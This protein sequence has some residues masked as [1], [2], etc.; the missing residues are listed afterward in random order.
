MR[1]TTKTILRTGFSC[2]LLFLVSACSTK[3]TNADY[4]V[5]P[6]PQ[7][8]QKQEGEGFVLS[9][10]TT[11][12]HPEGNE[13]LKRIACFLSEYIQ[14]TTGHTLSVSEEAKDDNCIV[15][16]TGLQHDNAEAYT[17]T[18][19]HSQIILKGASPA[20]VFY[21]AQTLRKAIDADSDKADVLFAPVNIEDYP[22]FGYRGMM[23][24]ISRHFF[25]KEF[26]KT[27]I[28]LLALHN[29]NRFH[30]HLSDDQG[31]RIEIKKYPELTEK[32][33]MRK[34]TVIGNNT[35]KYD[36]KPYGGFYTQ[37]DAR[38][39]VAYAAERFITII[40]EIDLPGHMLAALKAYPQI[41]CTGGPYETA[42][43]WGV[44]DDV[45]CA[46]NEETYVFLKGVFDEILDIFPSEYIH[47]GGDECPKVRWKECPK[48]QAKIKE[49]KLKA[50]SHH[51]A[52]DRLQSYVI[53][54]MEEYLNSKG[55]KIIG[56]DE[57][58]EGGLAP[59]ATVMSWRGMNGAI[60]A[61]KQG[62]D[63]ILTPTS[64]FYFDYYQTLDVANAPIAFNGYVPIEKVYSFNP[65]PDVLSAD[66]A[67]HIIGVQA[68]LWTEY[69][70]SPEQALYMVLPRMDAL[71]E[72][73]WMMQENRDYTAFQQRL[74]RML[75]YYDRRGYNYSR[76]MFDLKV[77]VQ[78][79]PESSSVDV[80]LSTPDSAAIYYTLDGSTPT[81]KS[82]RYTEPVSITG[83]TDFQAAA[84]RS[85]VSSTVYEQHFEFNKATTKPVVLNQ[86]LH[87]SYG[88]GG[89]LS[90][91]NGIKGSP[92][93]YKDDAWLG[94]IRGD[95]E[96]K[97]DLEELTDISS[98]SFD[99]YVQTG[100]WVFGATKLMVSVS[101][102][103]ENYQAVFE[104]S[105]PETTEHISGVFP[106]KADFA[107]VKTRYVKLS[108]NKVNAMPE[109]HLG[110]GSPAF[111]F[112]DEIVIN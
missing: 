80:T 41:G 105:Y 99:T 112:M 71:A 1:K 83:S 86:P 92:K 79:N 24:D 100:D 102:N 111:L 93:S 21:G 25:P 61:A 110:K 82:I 87:R 39:I 101:D 63:A 8:I 29:M 23:L 85:G 77:D 96:I 38:E 52:E 40:P 68:N 65:I 89:P 84:F 6:L 88:K 42:T 69:I 28:D 75:K 46:G 97:I 73:Q 66:E 57:I 34:E 64:H 15:L 35:E 55:R 95:V 45:L 17:L 11:I 9:R 26:V 67:K 59:N 27:Y 60:E 48:C 30:W 109:W 4:E 70:P 107:P 54:Y 10:S 12:V 90:L 58:L 44:F 7:H 43:K 72:V 74:L 76:A 62:N 98:V 22:R 108:I 37:E 78:V 33:S 47:I 19:N 103:D 16:Q 51:S 104:E 18:V 56:W 20:G 53:S 50:D 49:L 5:I 36:G 2:L 81:E 32:G 13:D 3:T 94:L 31:W 91:V 14:F 106:L